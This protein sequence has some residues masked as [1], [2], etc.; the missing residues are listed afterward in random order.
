MKRDTS[1]PA[2]NKSAERMRR[3][4]ERRK[5]GVLR[6]ISFELLERDI[7]VLRRYGGLSSGANP[8]SGE[9]ETALGEVLD[10]LERTAPHMV[11]QSLMVTE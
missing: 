5:R 3:L 9:I 2:K 4:R 10:R 1:Q 11:I 8:N 7:D 6:V